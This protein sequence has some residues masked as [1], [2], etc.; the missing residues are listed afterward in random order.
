MDNT[1]K[2]L[3]TMPDTCMEIIITVIIIRSL[4]DDHRNIAC[5]SIHLPEDRDVVLKWIREISEEMGTERTVMSLQMICKETDHTDGHKM[6]ISDLK[7]QNGKW[8]KKYR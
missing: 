8:H 5:L 1:Y 7:Q 4:M 3:S 2:A 6:I